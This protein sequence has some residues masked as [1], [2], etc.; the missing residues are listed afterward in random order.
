MQN[1]GIDD[2]IQ[3]FKATRKVYHKR[4]IWAERWTRGEVAWRDD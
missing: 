3:D 1:K 2:F 4:A